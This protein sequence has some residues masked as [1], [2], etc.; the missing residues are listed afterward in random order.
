M[1]AIRPYQPKDKENVRH[2]CIQTGPKAA[3]QEG[4]TREFILTAFCD[5]YAEC[6]P[7]NSFVIADDN[8]EAVGYIFCG[9]D[10][11]AY[12]R[13]YLKEHVPRLKGFSRLKGRVAAALPRWLVKDYPAHLHIDILPGYQRMGLGSQ[14]M[15]AL[16]ALLR[17]KGIPGVMLGVG[18]D[19]EKGLNFYKKY[20]FKALLRIPGCVF[21]GLEL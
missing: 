21:M 8:D 20:G 10:F 13:R 18:S 7:H 16:T 11:K 14:L 1:P 4:P 12:R 17:A 3:L 15:D 6:E 19:N 5:Y 2:V 9:E